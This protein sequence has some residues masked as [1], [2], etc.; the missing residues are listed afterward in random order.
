M[1]RTLPL[2]RFRLALPSVP[3]S[4]LKGL[5]GAVDLPTPERRRRYGVMVAWAL[6]GEASFEVEV[7]NRAECPALVQ[8]R[9]LEEGWPLIG[10]PT[11]VSLMRPR[12]MPADPGE[13]VERAVLAADAALRAEVGEVLR[14]LMAGVV[15]SASVAVASRFAEVIREAARVGYLAAEEALSL[16]A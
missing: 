4:A 11:R 1:K 13:L 14:A 16:A 9:A 6:L 10:T 7:C 3:E 12:A 8:L 2:H 15:P 5:P